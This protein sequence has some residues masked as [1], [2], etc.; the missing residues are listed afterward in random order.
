MKSRRN[1]IDTLR[2]ISVLSVIIFHIDNFVFPK[3]YLGV[4]IFF[5]I[6]G[7]VI[8]ISIVNNFKKDSFS[9][10]KFY[11]KRARR[12]LPNLLFIILIT[13]ILASLIL[14]TADLKRFSESLVSALAFV[15][16]F[17]FWLTGGYFSTNDQLK[18]LL[19]LW[20]LSVEEQFYLFFPIFLFFLYKIFKKINYFLIGIIIVSLISFFLNLYFL[21]HSDTI[22]FL[23]PTRAWQFGIGSAL[24][25]TPNLKIKNE[26]FD[27]F[28]LIIAVILIIY[29]FIFTIDFL[30]DATLICVGVG[31]I[32]IREFDQ[33][34]IL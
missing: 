3:G 14:L 30:P 22:F 4:D 19:H 9:F 16:N 17:Y 29:N 11:L 32:L 20:S 5:V 25:L 10:S 15:S 31:L 28:Y 6:S 33:K 23:F 2:A 18:P 26:W 27:F 34:K 13:T 12:I 8:T 7:Y 1:D 24:A 21:S